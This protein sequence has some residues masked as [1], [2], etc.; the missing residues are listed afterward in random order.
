MEEYITTHFL[1]EA[2][3]IPTLNDVLEPEN[4]DVVEDRNYFLKHLT[5][6]INSS[7]LHLDIG[8]VNHKGIQKIGDKIRNRKEYHYEGWFRPSQI[9]NIVLNI[10]DKTQKFDE[11]CKELLIATG[12]EDGRC[13]QYHGEFCDYLKGYLKCL[14]IHLQE[15]RLIEMFEKIYRRC[16]LMEDIEEIDNY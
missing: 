7:R 16:K 6:C 12:H 13:A 5:Y 8:L 3:R 11:I 1:K 9:S 15:S 10:L 4:E 14:N 2:D